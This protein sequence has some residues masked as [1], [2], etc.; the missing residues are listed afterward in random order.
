MTDPPGLQVAPGVAVDSTGQHISLAVGGHFWTGNTASTP[1]SA[2]PNPLTAAGVNLPTSGLSGSMYLTIQFLETFNSSLKES[3]GFNI[4]QTVHTPWLQLVSTTNFT[5]DGTRLVLA[6]VTFDSA[7]NVSLTPGLRQGVSLPLQRLSV[8]NYGVQSARG[9][10]TSIGASLPEIGAVL[11]RTSAGGGLTI[12]ADTLGIQS[13]AG[14]KNVF[15]DVAGGKVGVG[16]T[17]PGYALDVKGTIN[18]TNVLV[19]GNPLGESQW[20]RCTGGISYPSGNVGIGTTAPGYALDVKGTINA[21]DVLIRGTPIGESQWQGPRGMI[22]YQG[23]VGIG[24]K[25]P[26]YPLEVNGTISATEVHIGDH[27]QPVD[28]GLYVSSRTSELKSVK[29]V[30]AIPTAGKGLIFVAEVDNMLQFRKFDGGGKRADID[31]KTLTAKYAQQTQDLKKLLAPLWPPHTL[32]PSE[33]GQV[34]NAVTQMLGGVSPGCALLAEYVVKGKAGNGAMLGTPH[35]AGLFR[36]NVGVTG[37]INKTACKFT[38][39]HPVDPANKYLVHSVVESPEMMNVYTGTAVTGDDG[40]VAVQLPGYFEALNGNVTYQVTP[41]G[42]LA[43]AAVIRGVEQG[44]FVIKTD[45]PK[46]TVCWLVTGVRQDVYAKANP[47]VVEEDK[48]KLEQGTYLYPTLH[49]QSISKQMWK[50]HYRS[51]FKAEPLDETP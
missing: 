6:E 9:G 46:V 5:N 28:T 49:G 22:S 10:G 27:K 26:R 31:E 25:A 48:P 29:D 23:L 21:T 50:A 20:Q 36:G 14:N 16:T 51:V 8:C 47:I 43:L 7:G 18:A 11:P 2:L 40:E 30:S 41:F 13:I 3:S 34:I 42:Q 33:E 32:T 37:T 24:T 4:Y 39:D 15:I 12:Q 1:E 38:I 19:G 45:K 35:G 44:Q 17:A